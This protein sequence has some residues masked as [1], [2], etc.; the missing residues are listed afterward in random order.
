MSTLLQRCQAVSAKVERLMLAHRHASQQQRVQERSREWMSRREKQ[1]AVN[2]RATCL[3]LDGESETRINEKRMQLRYNAVQVLER[4]RSQEDIGQLTNDAAWERLL[5]SLDCLVEQLEASGKL[6]WK[7]FV[8]EQGTLEDPAWLRDRAPTTPIN[9]AALAAYRNSHS[10]YSGL[11]KLAM[12][13]SADDVHQLPHV[14]AA[15]RTEVAKIK[16]D[17]PPD[18]QHFFQAVQS[19][20]ASMASVTSGVLTWLSENGQLERYRIRSVG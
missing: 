3:P 7:G 8:E 16:F 11:I 13:R 15:C 5:A 4:L 12:P 20:N 18:V 2:A 9:D 19:G 1:R 6:A 14:I 10:V 17:V